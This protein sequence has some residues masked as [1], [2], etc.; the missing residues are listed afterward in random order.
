M[1][2]ELDGREMTKILIALSTAY[3]NSG[4][5][6]FKTIHDRLLGEVLRYKMKMHGGA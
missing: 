5:K 3:Q 1:K 4:T 6:E 2:V